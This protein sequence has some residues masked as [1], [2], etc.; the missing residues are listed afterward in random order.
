MFSRRVWRHTQCVSGW[1]L[2]WWSSITWCRA[3]SVLYLQNRT[4]RLHL[5]PSV[6]SRMWLMSMPCAIPVVWRQKRSLVTLSSPVMPTVIRWSWR[7]W[8]RL[9]W[10]AC[11][12]AW[13][14]RTTTSPLWWVWCSRLLVRTP[15]RLPSRW[16]PN[17]R[18]RLN[19]SLRAWSTRST[20]T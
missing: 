15:M 2:R 9:N 13:P 1:S 8:Q 5:V 19:C 6:S 20:T 4:L 16:R 12:I 10:V 18:N 17:W 11:S 3:I 7:M 14:W